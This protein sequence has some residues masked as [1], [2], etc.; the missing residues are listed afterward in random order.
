LESENKNLKEN[1]TVLNSILEDK[2]KN[3]GNNNSEVSSEVAYSSIKDD[4]ISLKDKY[5]PFRSK[6]LDLKDKPLKLEPKDKKLKKNYSFLNSIIKN[7]FKNLGNNSD[8]SSTG[9][10]YSS[11]KGDYSSLEDENNKLKLINSDLNKKNSTF[12]IE[13]SNL[14]KNYSDLTKVKE[15]LFKENMILKKVNKALKNEYSISDDI[16]S[17]EGSLNKKEPVEHLDNS[18]FKTGEIINSVV[19]LNTP[20]KKITKGN[21]DG[22]KADSLAS[23]LSKL[24]E[25]IELDVPFTL[26]DLKEK[27]DHDSFTR[28]ENYLW[29]LQERDLL[30]YRDSNG[31]ILKS[32]KEFIE[33]CIKYYI[34]IN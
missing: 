3:L 32:S 16:D 31:Y 21:V 33:F 34:S 8:D 7:K 24:L 15:K 29:E 9:E 20:E 26:D 18:K 28:F 2:F 27:F 25:Y 17:G 12:E 11:V 10:V 30:I 4:N 23:C 5:R 19:D 13:Y 6:K 22:F 14:K 1:Y